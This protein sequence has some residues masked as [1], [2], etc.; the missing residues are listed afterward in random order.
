MLC[1]SNPVRCPEAKTAS[2]KTQRVAEATQPAAARV[3]RGITFN[4]KVSDIIAK[5]EYKDAPGENKVYKKKATLATPRP[6]LQAESDVVETKPVDKS[7]LGTRDTS[8]WRKH[9]PSAEKVGE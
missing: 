4:V 1:S 6:T 3:R 2:S 7:V 8:D 5:V 9:I